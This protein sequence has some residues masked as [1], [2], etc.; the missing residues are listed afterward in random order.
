MKQFRQI[1]K[2]FPSLAFLHFYLYNLK[3]KNQKAIF[4]FDEKFLRYL[5]FKQPC[6]RS[7]STQ[8]WL[9]YPGVKLY[10]EVT[11]AVSTCLTT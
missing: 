2:A 11:E 10:V 6:T 9:E 4:I 8:P 1:I 7:W 5:G 3:R